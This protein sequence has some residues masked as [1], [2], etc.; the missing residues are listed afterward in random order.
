[1]K[2]T[3]LVPPCFDHKQPAER[4]AG[5][6]RVVYLAPNIYELSVAAV[7]EQLPGIKVEYK[8]FVYNPVTP[9]EFKAF[10]ASDDSDAYLI[11][12][13]NLSIST[14][15]AAIATLRM[16]RPQ[17]P[18]VLMG[19]GPTHFI[20][21]CLVDKHVYVVRGEPE[22]T[23]RELVEALRDG[24]PVD[25]IQGISYI[26]P[27]GK[28]VNNRPRPLIKDLDE[29]PFAARHLI[30]GAVY[31]NPKLKLTPYTTMIT[32]RNC[33]FK[34]IYCVPSSLSFAREIEFRKEHGRKPTI[35][36]RSPENV[37]KEVAMLAAQGIKAIG[38]M[39][40]NFIWNEERTAAICAIMK[41]YG[42]V[43]GCEARV[44]AITEPIAKMLGESGCRYIDLGVESFNDEILA[45]IKKGIKS[46]DIYR[47]VGLLKKYGVPV[48]L[49][50]LI[51]SSPLE[52]RETVLHTLR[53]ANKLDVDQVM[54][55]IVSPFP[56]T[57]YYDLCKKNGW[58]EGDEY[59]PIDVQRESI[60][61]LPNLSAREM[62][63][64]LF[65]NNIKFFLSWRFIRKQ[66][67][68]FRSPR[69]FMAALK[70]LKIKLFG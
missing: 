25:G 7:L 52:T 42:I 32:S 2:L 64:L 41:K 4:T 22:Y 17:V 50:I 68:R 53:E 26:G 55:N 13:V 29:L 49:N 51:G 59:V 1:M 45:Y 46:A 8:D 67:H 24:S 5:C 10:F 6:T 47:A 28:I 18:V 11:W 34:C 14:D 27:D 57:E 70:A 40:D 35:G 36:F 31:H 16:S 19:P 60:L 63:K 61:M 15:L 9:E 12:T 44:D 39:D 33:P 62:E 56:A 48:K 66:I 3:F 69:E 43:W 20:K 65:H 30:S 37:E 38:F 21:K 54:F 58:I 23:V